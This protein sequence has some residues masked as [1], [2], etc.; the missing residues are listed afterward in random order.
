M[1]RT[2]NRKSIHPNDVKFRLIGKNPNDATGECVETCLA[3]L[4]ARDIRFP[5]NLNPGEKRSLI[6]SEELEIKLIRS[7]DAYQF[8]YRPII[9]GSGTTFT[10]AMFTVE[11]A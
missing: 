1:A 5:G 7:S 2:K 6:K 9:N 3:E 4:K 11:E 10:S 8:F